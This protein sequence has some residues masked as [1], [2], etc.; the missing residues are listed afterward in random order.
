MLVFNLAVVPTTYVV[1]L[2]FFIYFKYETFFF[3]VIDLNFD[4]NW[5]T[6]CVVTI[7]DPVLQGKHGM[8]NSKYHQIVLPQTT[9]T[10]HKYI[11]IL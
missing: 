3:F 2:P 9:T 1:I 6:M 11:T 10:T 8:G 4:I 5:V 7:R